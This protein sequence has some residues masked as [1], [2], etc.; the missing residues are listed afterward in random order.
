MNAPARIVRGRQSVPPPPLEKIFVSY[1]ARDRDWALWIG[2]T[3]RESGYQPLVHEWEVGA[4]GNIAQWMDESIAA[5]DRMIGVFTDA[6]AR[7]IYSSSERWAAYWH[8]P[9]DRIGFFVPIEVERVSD[10]PPLIR[11]LKR[12]SLVGMSD[13]HAECALLEFLAPPQPL[14]V[15]PPFPGG[16]SNAFHMARADPLP[17]MRP[18]WPAAAKFDHH[19]TPPP[20]TIGDR[21]TWL[22][23]AR[24]AWTAAGRPSGLDPFMV[25]SDP[26]AYDISYYEYFERRFAKLWVNVLERVEPGGGTLIKD[27]SAAFQ[28][29]WRRNFSWETAWKQLLPL[30]VYGGTLGA[31]NVVLVELASY[32]CIA[33]AIP[34]MVIDRMLD[35]AV[36]LKSASDAAFCTVAYTKGLTG[37]R[38]LRLPS[39]ASIEDCFLVHTRQMYNLMLTEHAKR[40]ALP[41]SLPSE[42]IGDYFT[43]T[44]RLFSSIFFGVLPRWA[45][46]VAGKEIPS[47]IVESLEALRCVR[48]LNDELS[49]VKDDLTHGLI[50]LPWLFAI[51]EQPKLAGLI[52]A[53]WQSPQRANADVAS[54]DCL[55]STNAMQR[56]HAKSLEFLS[57][58]MHVTRMTFGSSE[59]FEITMLHNVRWAHLI[60]MR[61]N[62]YTDMPPRQPSRPNSIPAPNLIT[63]VA[64]A[65]TL[66]AR[67]NGSVLMSL[68]F[69]RG[70]LRWELPAGVAEDHETMEQTACR[71]TLEETGRKVEVGALIALCWHYSNELAKGWMGI[72]FEANLA[73]EGATGDFKI[74]KRSALGENKINFVRNPELYDSVALDACDFELVRREYAFRPAAHENILASGF[75]D[76]RRIPPQRIH[77]LHRELLEAHWTK[78]PIKLLVGDADTDRNAYDGEVP[79]YFV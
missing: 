62:S 2:V 50:T 73:A 15:R 37:I 67:D 56:V 40:L 64:G 17:A 63:P 7:A 14:A 71:E 16:G 74:V 72:F 1:T 60:R 48:Q 47:A 75:V 70:M 79:L 3:L 24:A 44:S 54:I 53:F 22:G 19:I 4:G 42:F 32:Y 33:Q 58:S 9:D 36:D 78:Q 8:D 66:V 59:A 5:A 57:K 52:Q 35:E 41:A 25:E 55:R 51:E 46:I 13:A 49:D 77:P 31:N 12:L 29:A 26:V 20:L 21:A 27:E 61:Q 45:Y 18:T 11:A 6:Y 30:F 76:W 65:G 43:P 38:E 39:S 28:E 69:K 34:S 68:V 10:W 23:F